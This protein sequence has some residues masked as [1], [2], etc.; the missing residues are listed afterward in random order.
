MSFLFP[1][2]FDVHNLSRSRSHRATPQSLQNPVTILYKDIPGFPHSSVA[3][4]T[5]ELVFGEVADK[6]VV[7]MRGR[8]HCYEG[9]TMQEVG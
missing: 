2:P 4:H 8:F 3:G 9:W 6:L 1:F 7:C 5:N